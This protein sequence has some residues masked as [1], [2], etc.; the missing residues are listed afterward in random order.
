MCCDLPAASA[1]RRQAG[2]AREKSLV[3]G[4]DC[5]TGVRIEGIKACASTVSFAR[6][7]VS[8]SGVTSYRSSR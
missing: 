8:C 5:P 3:I 6:Y 1:G 4:S 7:D 2:W